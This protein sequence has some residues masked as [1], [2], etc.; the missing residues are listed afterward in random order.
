MQGPQVSPD[1]RWVWNGAQWVPNPAAPPMYYPP[2]PFESPRFRALFVMIFLGVN[3]F[4]LLV[5]LV[6]DIGLIAYGGDLKS[7]GDA[8]V[9]GF[10]LVALIF[11]V[12][13]FGSLVPAVVLFCMWLH[14][15][16][17]NMPALGAPDPRWTPAGAVG[18]CF[19]P[20]LNFVHPLYGVID[21]WRGSDPSMIRADQA[22]RL[23]R[24]VSPLI[25]VWWVAWLG[26]RFISVIS[27]P[28]V[29]SNNP[30]TAAGGAVIEL[31]ANL[32]TAV[33]AGL[34]ILVV[35]E[36]TKRQDLKHELMAS[37]RLS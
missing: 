12:L 8:A 6:V 28:L 27:N 15:V 31:I 34:A 32:A 21:A 14:R 25:I 35:F 5:G 24:G 11:L 20:F 36:L 16:V 33:A 17:R 1:G 7:G 3:G 18:R 10:G 2:R 4:S 23:R 22:V 26:G 19:I 13:Y 30:G 37:G 9:I 29:G